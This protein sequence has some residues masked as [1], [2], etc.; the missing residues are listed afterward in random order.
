MSYLS[1]ESH[2]PLGLRKCG[3]PKTPF[4]FSRRWKTHKNAGLVKSSKNS[5]EDPARAWKKAWKTENRRKWSSRKICMTT[6]FPPGYAHR[7]NTRARI[8]TQK[9]HLKNHIVSYKHFCID[10]DS[11]ERHE[12]MKES[13]LTYNYKKE[14]ILCT[15]LRCRYFY[16]MYVDT[17]HTGF[18]QLRLLYFAN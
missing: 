4:D 14:I 1:R 15:S 17:N 7:W 13:F 5:I 10:S 6:D 9:N 3:A 2:M 11:D 12:V 16:Q 18:P 8:R